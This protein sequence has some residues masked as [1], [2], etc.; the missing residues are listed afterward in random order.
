GQ[1]DFDD[2]QGE[3]RYSAMKSYCQSKLAQVLFTHELS[4]RI[5]G[6]G[7]T[8]NAVHPGAVRT[9]WGDEAGALGI[10][11]RI[12]RPFM[13]S[14]E[15]GAS[16]PFYGATSPEV[17]GVSGK[18]YDKKKDTRSSKE[19]YDEVESE[20]LWEISMKLSG[21]QKPDS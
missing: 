17:E 10:G 12:A 1:I 11:I 3:K 2:L 13:L 14:A 8:V 21:L 4:K 19:S 5:A 16:T 6:T 9:H 18:Y 15:K 20:K 7:I